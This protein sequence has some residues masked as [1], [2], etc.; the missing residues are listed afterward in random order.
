MSLRM[1]QK[2]LIIGSTGFLGQALKQLLPQ[3]GFEVYATSRAP[4]NSDL[5]LDL[6]HP[7]RPQLESFVKSNSIQQAI[8]C[9]A[10]SDIDLC[11]KDPVL[12]QR[13]NVEALKELALVLK[14][15]G[16]K[17]LF[18]SSDYVFDGQNLNYGE[19]SPPSPRTLYGRHKLEFEEFLK[20]SFDEYLIFRTSKLMS[21]TPHPRCILHQVVQKLLR[22]EDVPA[23]TDQWITP[24]FVEDIAKAIALVLPKNISGL[25]HLATHE[26]FTRYE[27]AVRLA[28]KHN[29]DRN[30]IKPIELKSLSF[31]EP[32][33]HYNTLS[34][35]KIQSAV[36]FQPTPL[37]Q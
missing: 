37:F 13:V 19:D 15:Y 8:I 35:R 30:L 28:Q 27:I 31:L 6:L 34:A 5:R 36:G 2:T 21:Q 3:I 7:I 33:P 25:Y 12:S 14:E 16:I 1:A 22:G 29:L 18:F 23:F 24:V 11:A 20:K 17:P 9:S 26:T 32:R 4:Q 10:I